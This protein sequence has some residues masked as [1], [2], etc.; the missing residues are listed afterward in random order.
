MS[1]SIKNIA[2]ALALASTTAAKEVGCFGD[3]GSLKLEDSSVYQSRGH[4][5]DVCRN[6]GSSVA[7]I[8]KGNKCFC[9]DD[10]PTGE[11]LP[12]SECGAPCDGYPADTCELLSAHPLL[13]PL[14]FSRAL[15]LRNL[16]ALTNTSF[17]SGGGENAWIV[18]SIG[19]EDI[20]T[21][22]TKYQRD[23]D[24]AGEDKNNDSDNASDNV[25]DSKDGG[26]DSDSTGEDKG[27]DSDDG[28]DGKSGSDEEEKGG[29]GSGGGEQS[30]E[31]SASG[32]DGG[33][34]GP[35]ATESG[36]DPT[37]TGAGSRLNAGIA[38]GLFAIAAFAISI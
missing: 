7:A 13:I 30:A 25:E 36:S 9:G 28:K 35:S 4:C 33:N 23:D 31:E 12:D 5:L 29:S 2:I 38:A 1:P 21:R 20:S 34:E 11:K 8:T 18:I 3:S 6:K 26:D 37:E 32:T 27:N 22:S 14:I 10:I 24:P 15:V 19:E 16:F 17:I